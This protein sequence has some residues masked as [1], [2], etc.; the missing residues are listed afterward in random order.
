M[1]ISFTNEWRN[2]KKVIEEIENT[3][4]QLELFPGR[5]TTKVNLQKL[6]EK[7]FNNY[8]GFLNSNNQINEFAAKSIT[9]KW[10]ASNCRVLNQSEVADWVNKQDF[11]HNNIVRYVADDSI[12]KSMCELC[13]KGG[14]PY[15]PQVKGNE[16]GCATSLVKEI[17]QSS[18]RYTRIPQT[19]KNF[20][21]FMNG[22]TQYLE[23]DISSQER[24]DES[25]IEEIM[26]E[27]L[28]PVAKRLGYRIQ[29]EYPIYDEGRMELRYSLDMVFIEDGSGRLL[30]DVETDGLTFH[31]GHQQMAN[32]RSRDRWLLIRGVPTMRFTSR[33]VFNDLDDCVVQVESALESLYSKG[34]RNRNKQKSKPKKGRH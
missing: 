6:R 7:L 20:Q 32:D 1:P 11:K 26:Y 29:R 12:G 8:E 2:Y 34:N 9:Q 15:C 30:L 17:V 23:K 13:F 16:V 21:M 28:K 14:T 24:N 18:E 25:P 31:S 5:K 10:F 19:E 3:Q 4:A 22:A 27:A 33:E